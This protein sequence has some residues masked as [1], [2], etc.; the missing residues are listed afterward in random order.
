MVPGYARARH[1]VVE[2]RSSRLAEYFEHLSINRIEMGDPG[3]GIIASGV[4][5]QYARE[6]F[7]WA[8]FLKLGTVWPLPAKKI[9]RFAASVKRVVVVEELDPFLE[10]QVRLLGIDCLGKPIFPVV[11]ELTPGRVRECALKGGLLPP[12]PGAATVSSEVLALANELPTRPPMLCPGCGHRPVF[13]A[14]RLYKVL[15]F[16]DIGCYGLGVNP[17]LSGYHTSGCMGASIGVAHG[18]DKAGVQERRAAI[19][20]DSTFFH[21]GIAPLINVLYN[22]GASTVIVLDNRTTA[23]TGHQDHPGSGRTLLKEETVAVAIEDLARAAGFKKVD[24]VDP[25]DFKALRSLIREHVDS[26][27]PSVLVARHPCTLLTKK[28]TLPTKWTRAAATT[29]GCV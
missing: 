17:P 13:Y 4:S 5:Y 23:M 19:I 1:A 7:P 20:G 29:A 3:I 28:L 2:E 10:E 6:V 27:E 9:R 11:G 26:P 18:A 8:S 14:L 12:E 15:V 22:R 25:F 24:V 16:G 21:S